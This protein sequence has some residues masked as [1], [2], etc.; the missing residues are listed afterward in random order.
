MVDPFEKQDFINLEARIEELRTWLGESTA[1]WKIA[2][3]G[4]LLEAE[5]EEEK[6]GKLSQRFDVSCWE[7]E[8]MKDTAEELADE[9]LERLAE[10]LED[11]SN[12]TVISEID[13]PISPISEEGDVLERGLTIPGLR[14]WNQGVQRG[15]VG[16]ESCERKRQVEDVGGRGEAGGKRR[17]MGW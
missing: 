9:F 7:Y 8:L 16:V 1:E 13:R 5:E 15:G 10:E 6:T 2:E 4:M 17:R 14:L 12:A 3:M 11:R